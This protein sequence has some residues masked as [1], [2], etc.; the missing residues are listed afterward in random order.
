MKMVAR[1]A[2]YWKSQSTPKFNILYFHPAMR[3]RIAGH[4]LPKFVYSSIPIRHDLPMTKL[5][6]IA[7]TTG[8]A[9]LTP[10]TA[11]AAEK[12][13]GHGAEA[14]PMALYTLEMIWATLCS[15]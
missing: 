11:L 9:L 13:D 4:L 1:L 15:S 2:C 12:A 8:F 3:T 14:D 10:M 6:T 5:K 7:L